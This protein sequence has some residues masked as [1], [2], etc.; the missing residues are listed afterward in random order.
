VLRAAPGLIILGPAMAASPRAVTLASLGLV[1]L[2][3]VAAMRV[4]A[5]S[6]PARA[7]ASPPTPASLPAPASPNA[8][9]SQ[10]A[11][12]SPLAP[13]AGSPAPLVVAPSPRARLED[14]QNTIDVFRAAA[15]GT[16]FVA[17]NRLVRDWNMRALEVPAGSGTGFI[18]DDA[19]HVVTN[20]HVIDAGRGRGSYAVTLYNHKTYDATLVG[21]EPN[22]DIAVLK[23]D[24]PAAE[25]APIR[26]LEVDGALEVGQKAIAIG[27]PFG[28]DHTLTTGVISALGR[29]VVGYGGVTIRDMIQTDASINPGNSGGPL[30]DSQG[31]LIGMNTMIF[32]K[33]GGST[34]IGFAVPV[35]T[36][37][38]IVPQL[39]RSGKVERAGLGIRFLPDE[40]AR[41]A[42]VK[43]I[44][45]TGV[46]P[47]SPAARA[48]LVPLRETRAGDLLLG[49]VVVGID[50]HVVASYDDLFN[51]LERYKAGDRVSVKILRGAATVAVSLDLTA[52]E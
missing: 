14:E 39:I 5:V 48:G 34:G 29:E 49:D 11:P 18:W 51:V 16:V 36:I 45:V 4:T 28:L 1:C 33:S 22:R 23:I 31:R 30:I 35:S 3:C 27:N 38:R 2:V 46:I 12:V 50:E 20:Y 15:P 10:P 25:L 41:R 13:A 9:A 40:I 8:P 47:G 32:S 42:G 24:A 17:Q 52:L 44:I 43:G 26:A 6:A 21:G 37:R 7:T 19:G